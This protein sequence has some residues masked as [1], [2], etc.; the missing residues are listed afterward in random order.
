M[1][2]KIKTKNTI[3]KTNNEAFGAIVMKLMGDFTLE[4]IHLE[5]L[6]GQGSQVSSTIP[7]A[8]IVN[9]ITKSVLPT[10]GLQEQKEKPKEV[11]QRSQNKINSKKK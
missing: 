6:K 11:P 8:W 10:S 1:K 5:E 2:I 4:M 7:K 3:F 9:Y